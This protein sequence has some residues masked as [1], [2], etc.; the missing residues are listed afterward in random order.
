MPSDLG[1]TGRAPIRQIIER[2]FAEIEAFAVV[3]H[4]MT[5]QGSGDNGGTREVA[6]YWLNEGQALLFRRCP[7]V[8]RRPAVRDG[9]TKVLVAYR[10]RQLESAPTDVAARDHGKPLRY[11]LIIINLAKTRY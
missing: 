6:E 4:R 2:K 5:P 11:Q 7:R 8:R 1:S 10:R 9:L 3:P